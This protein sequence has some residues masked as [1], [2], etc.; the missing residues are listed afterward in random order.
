MMIGELY[1]DG[2][3][4][5]VSENTSVALTIN[6]N[7]FGDVSKI[8]SNN[9]Y[10]IKLPRTA[11]NEGIFFGAARVQH[12]GADARITH[13][14]R[15]IVDGVPVI[16][17]GVAQLL[18]AGDEFEISISWG[19]FPKIEDIINGNKTL[20][21]LSSSASIRF[22]GFNVPDYYTAAM[23]RGY[24][25]ASYSPFY[26]ERDNN[27]MVFDALSDVWMQTQTITFNGGM[28]QTGEVGDMLTLQPS[29]SANRYYAIADYW[30]GTYITFYNLA[31]GTGCY[32]W[33]IVDELNIVIACGNDASKIGYYAPTRAAK[34][35]LNT[36]NI[37]A[38]AFTS[39]NV[40]KNPTNSIQNAENS[41]FYILPSVSVKWILTQ[42]QQDYG[43]NVI[44]SGAEKDFIDTLAIP[45]VSMESGT[46]RTIYNFE[47]SVLPVATDHDAQLTIH[48]ETPPSIFSEVIGTET[49]TLNAIIN[50]TIEFDIQIWYYHHVDTPSVWADGTFH[51]VP[52]YVE[53]DV[54]YNGEIE[55]YNIGS[56]DGET[57]TYESS[58]IDS[59]NYVYHIIAGTGKVDIEHAEK[60]T[61]KITKGG[62]N[63]WDIQVYQGIIRAR[64]DM[65]T[66]VM[67]GEYFPIVLNLPEI[68]IVDLLKC[69]CALTATRP[70]QISNIGELHMVGYTFDTSMAVDWSEKVMNIIIPDETT[71]TLNEWARQNWWRWKKDDKTIGDYD[72]V[73]QLDNASETEKEVTFPFAASD[74]GNVPLWKMTQQYGSNNVDTAKGKSIVSPT[75][76]GCEPRLMIAKE[77]ATNRTYLTFDGL[78]LQVIINDRYDTIKGYL[79]NITVIKVKAALSVV[80]IMSFDEKKLVYLRQFASYFAVQKIEV[81]IGEVATLTLLR[82]II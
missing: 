82:V 17:N 60:V 16:D 21:D 38:S 74:A 65:G 51:F 41:L 50:G 73:L 1:I 32:A 48:V 5:D 34:I 43:V 71:Y 52:F 56:L 53:M 2:V 49:T 57:N 14:A 18:S 24:F 77:D 42:I 55:A 54:E 9:T 75:F 46:G 29:P 45:C 8:A 62:S 25:F 4:V 13:T 33:C 44:W 76:E 47:G 40:S 69:L 10:T 15:Y 23:Q 80:D 36:N 26:I 7:L 72:G 58:Y 64:V 19:V 30:L 35:I 22:G 63:R 79:D 37:S 39:V 68:K 6:S 20:K 78:N 70:T 27:W 31:S 81:N 11:K 66:Q 28:V 67:R 59:D 12:G 61:F 3:L